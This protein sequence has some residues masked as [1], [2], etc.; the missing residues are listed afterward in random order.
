VLSNDRDFADQQLL[1]D[2]FQCSNVVQAG[3]IVLAQDEE[4]ARLRSPPAAW[5][6]AG[7]SGE[8]EGANDRDALTN[9]DSTSQ[10]RAA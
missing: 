8:L 5:S 10:P 9:A 7:R 3:E 1:H 6:G 2:L 4:C